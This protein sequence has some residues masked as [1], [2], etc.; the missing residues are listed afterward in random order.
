MLKLIGLSGQI[1]I[2][3]IVKGLSRLLSSYPPSL[4]RFK[5]KHIDE[6]KREHPDAN[7]IIVDGEMFQVVWKQKC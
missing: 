3:E 5:K 6:L 1:E 4:F 7:L 2:S